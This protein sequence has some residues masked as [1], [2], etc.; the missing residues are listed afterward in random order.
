[1]VRHMVRSVVKFGHW[2]D[3]ITAFRA[4]N[5]AAVRLGLPPYRLYVKTSMG[6]R[7]EVFTEAEYEDAADM[8]RRTEAAMDA[9]AAY[10]AALDLMASH[11]VDGEI[12]DYLLS[13][14]PVD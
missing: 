6:I 3:W 1:M 14:L 10:A 8:G 4:A 7:N 5:E 11:L 12:R 9:D 13:E 2:A